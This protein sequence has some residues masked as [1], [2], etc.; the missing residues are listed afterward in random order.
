MKKLERAMQ[1][2]VLR[3]PGRILCML[4]PEFQ[5]VTG[6][7]MSS[8]HND[9]YKNSLERAP[10]QSQAGLKGRRGRRPGAAEGDKGLTPAS[11][12]GVPRAPAP[13]LPDE[14]TPVRARLGRDCRPALLTCRPAASPSPGRRPAAPPPGCSAPA[15]RSGAR[16]LGDRSCRTPAAGATAARKGPGRFASSSAAPERPGEGKGV[17]VAVLGPRGPA[18]GLAAWNW[19]PGG[20]ERKGTQIYWNASTKDI[21]CSHEMNYL[22]QE[23]RETEVDV[24][25]V[26]IKTYLQAVLTPVVC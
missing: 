3:G 7:Y 21:H 1:L 19:A 17:R 24:D 26:W 6:I 20:G 15:A 23:L 25:T 16:C 22:Q 4:S 5:R 12:P 13:G 10:S 14:P 9:N 2:G 8:L 18:W 11:F